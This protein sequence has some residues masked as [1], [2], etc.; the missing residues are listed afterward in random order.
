[1]KL[2][3]LINKIIWH[4]NYNLDDYELIIIDRSKE[5]NKKAISLNSI[6]LKGNYIIIGDTYIPLYRILLIRNKK[7]GEIIYKSSRSMV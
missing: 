3:E 4:P 6:K 1:M 7:T 2:K 5:D